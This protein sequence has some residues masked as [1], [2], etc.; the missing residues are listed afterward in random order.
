MKFFIDTVNLEDIKKYIK[1]YNIDGVTS[2]PTIISRNVQMDFFK[3]YDEIKN[4]IG[5]KELHVQVSG[6]T[7]QQMVE[8]AVTITKEID[9]NVYV[10]I[11][12][13]EE[14]IRAIKECKEKGINVTATAIYSSQQAILA[15]FNG[16][17]YVAPYYNRI[18]N[19]NVDSTKV[20]SEISKI[21][22]SNDVKTEIIAASFKNTY[23]VMESLFAGANA[24]TVSVDLLS[25]ITSNAIVENAV[26]TFRNDWVKVYGETNI[27]NL[28]R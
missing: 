19:L 7:W 22:A 20:I 9:K 11:P 1:N 26:D 15:S 16:A 18:N 17:D 10:K 2:N 14:G 28:T 13:N 25:E 4:I 24:V 6:T 23:Q 8:D 3:L 27:S 12:V 5:N 21:Y